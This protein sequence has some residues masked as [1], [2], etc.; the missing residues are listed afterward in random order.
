M[1]LHKKKKII[2]QLALIFKVGHKKERKKERKN[3]V[4]KDR[5]RWGRNKIILRKTC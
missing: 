4:K 1:W 3:Y 5:W 2:N